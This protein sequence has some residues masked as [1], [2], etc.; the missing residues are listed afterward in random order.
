MTPTPDADMLKGVTVSFLDHVVGQEVDG[1]YVL[2]DLQGGGY[3]G[4]NEVGS[5]IWTL[6]QEGKTIRETFEILLKEY[7][8]PPE[9][10]SFDLQ[11]FLNGLHT[12]RLV[13]VDGLERLENT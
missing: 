10:L 11:K 1:E 4:L 8:V 9:Q 2:L 5:N 12:R 6:I 13:E 3:Y 7:D